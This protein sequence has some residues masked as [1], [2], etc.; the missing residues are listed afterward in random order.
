MN[1][2]SKH[3]VQYCSIFSALLA[4]PCLAFRAMQYSNP[5]VD[6]KLAV[7]SS[8]QVCTRFPSRAYYNKH[9][10]GKS[11]ILSSGL[12]RETLKRSSLVLLSHAMSS[13]ST[14]ST[15]PA[16][17]VYDDR[18]ISHDDPSHPEKSARATVMWNEMVRAGLVSRC[19][20]VKSREATEE[21]LKLVHSAEHVAAVNA[22]RARMD[23]STYFDPKGSPQAAR[24]AAGS[25]LEMTKQVYFICDTNFQAYTN[26]NFSGVPW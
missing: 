26:R 7:Q 23:E 16:S 14:I 10:F 24:L 9:A 13:A 18:H 17:V 1:L 25:V 3:F 6:Y 22:G 11:R 20:N 21:E 8:S 15:F 19:Y 2:K 4:R 5:I 12:P